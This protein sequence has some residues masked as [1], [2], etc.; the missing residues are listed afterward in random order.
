MASE[1]KRELG[2]ILYD[3]IH[4]FVIPGIAQDLKLLSL[5][6]LLEIIDKINK[7]TDTCIKCILNLYNESPYKTHLGFEIL[8]RLLHENKILDETTDKKYT[9][10]YATKLQEITEWR[11]KNMNLVEQHERK[12]DI[13]SK[14]LKYA[15]T[16]GLSLEQVFQKKY[17]LYKAKYMKLKKELVL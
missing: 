8:F 1:H 5:Q 17:L 4:K 15:Q 14:Y 2:Q 13:Q 10:E 12:Q 9:D 3:T 6:S 11:K 7:H 16:Y